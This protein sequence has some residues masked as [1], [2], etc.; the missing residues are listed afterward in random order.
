MNKQQAN[1]LIP[2]IFASCLSDFNFNFSDFG[3][4][5]EGNEGKAQSETIELE[6]ESIDRV[7]LS[8]MTEIS[9]LQSSPEP[10]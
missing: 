6:A 1:K 9:D 7:Q 10:Q 3:S 2:E 8:S 5:L 4:P